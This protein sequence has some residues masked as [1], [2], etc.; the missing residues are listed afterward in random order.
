MLRF[1]TT[2]VRRQAG[3]PRARC[4]PQVERLEQR[5]LPSTTPLPTLLPHRAPPP[6]HGHHRHGGHRPGLSGAAATGASFTDPT[7][8]VMNQGNIHVGSAVYIGPF[9]FLDGRPG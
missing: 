5:E 3:S 9:A 2:R 8:L 4:R 7:A 1:F 6:G